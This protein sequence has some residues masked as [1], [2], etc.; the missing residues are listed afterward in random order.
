MS[1]KSD[2]IYYTDKKKIV[3]HFI[4]VIRYWQSVI[5]IYTSELNE[6]RQWR[7]IQKVAFI[8]AVS[9]Q[10]ISAGHINRHRCYRPV[11]LY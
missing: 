1:G 11:L 8:H 5:A 2:D 6:Y 4:F 10:L 3:I 9:F 7:Q